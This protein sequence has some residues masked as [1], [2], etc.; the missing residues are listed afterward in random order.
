MIDHFIRKLTQIYLKHDKKVIPFCKALWHRIMLEKMAIEKEISSA[1]RDYLPIFWRETTMTNRSL[2]LAI[3]WL[4]I[5]NL[6][7]SRGGLLNYNLNSFV[8]K[9]RHHHIYS[10]FILISFLFSS[11]QVF[12]LYL[13]FSPLYPF[14]FLC[15]KLFLDCWLLGWEFWRMGEGCGDLSGVNFW[16]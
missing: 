11:K 16:R 3:W 12:H 7:V 9:C 15:G 1:I 5:A 6:S 10:L 8:V 13:L 14:H 2:F 4:I